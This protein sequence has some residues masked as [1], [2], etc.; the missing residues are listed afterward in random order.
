MVTLANATVD[1]T[2]K[3]TQLCNRLATGFEK[4]KREA[5]ACLIQV[6]RWSEPDPKTKLQAVLYA[7]WYAYEKDRVDKNQWNKEDVISR[8]RLLRGI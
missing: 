1:D 5:D 2:S 6:L 7:N 3:L 4:N 8:K